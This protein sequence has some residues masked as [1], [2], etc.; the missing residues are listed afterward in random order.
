MKK[1][2]LKLLEQKIPSF[3]DIMRK[4]FNEQ[5]D[6]ETKVADQ[7]TMSNADIGALQKVVGDYSLDKILKTIAIIAD[8]IGKHNEADMIQN[9][10]KDI[11]SS[12]DFNS[13]V[14][15]PYLQEDEDLTNGEIEI[16]LEDLDFEMSLQDEYQ[17]K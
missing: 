13:W 9:L 16:S 12:S 2:K 8:R 4:Y 5:E 11:D 14:N 3:S 6:V 17:D 10:A 7:E 15:D 1:S